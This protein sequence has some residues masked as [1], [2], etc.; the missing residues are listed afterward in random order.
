M[1]EYFESSSLDYDKEDILY[2]VAKIDGEIKKDFITPAE[3]I[4][5]RRKIL[6]TFDTDL[7]VDDMT[8]CEGIDDVAQG[9]EPDL[10]E[11][12]RAVKLDQKREREEMYAKPNRDAVESNSRVKKEA[13]E[14]VQKKNISKERVRTNTNF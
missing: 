2:S 14:G 12:T 10:K 4:E 11:R 9:Y 6:K 13:G 5:L 8:L 3:N 1:L 7:A